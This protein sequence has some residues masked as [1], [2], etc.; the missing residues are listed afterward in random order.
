MA[1]DWEL[2]NSMQEDALTDLLDV[3]VAIR[4]RTTAT[5][6]EVSALSL[7]TSIDLNIM[8]LREPPEM[9]AWMTDGPPEAPETPE[10]S[11]PVLP[12][13]VNLH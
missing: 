2:I 12:D 1:L 11:G 6:A 9:P 4:G 3:F 5:E 7:R 8:S 13:G 10:D